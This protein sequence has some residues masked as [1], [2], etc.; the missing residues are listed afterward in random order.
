LALVTL[1]NDPEHR[2]VLL[3]EEPENGVHAYRLRTLVH[4]L[5]DLATDFLDEEQIDQPLRQLLINTHSPVLVKH[6]IRAAQGGNGQSAFRPKLS[7]AYMA[8]HV[9]PEA[10]GTFSRITRLLPVRMSLEGEL[11]L[12]QEEGPL[13]LN[14]V[15]EYLESADTSR[16]MKTLRQEHLVG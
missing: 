5:R 10:S 2:G 7:F 4:L 12:S 13:A 3:F 8:S 6:M 15:I 9:Q 14:Q 1:K 16:L 11:G